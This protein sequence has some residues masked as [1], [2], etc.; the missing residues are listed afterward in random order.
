MWIRLVDHLN[1]MMFGNDHREYDYNEE[2]AS[3]EAQDCQPHFKY[4]REQWNEE[5]YRHSAKATS[6]VKG[7]YT[8]FI[9]NITPELDT[10]LRGKFKNKCYSYYSKILIWCPIR[11]NG[12]TI[13]CAVHNC[14]L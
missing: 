13:N 11:H 4:D 3:V 1:T 10:I 5:L 14:P 9:L 8:N 2:K 7:N 6:D 12:L